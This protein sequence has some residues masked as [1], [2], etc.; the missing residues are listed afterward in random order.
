[1]SPVPRHEA[2]G[3]RELEEVMICS[4]PFQLPE[5]RRGLEAGSPCSDQH[6]KVSSS[7]IPHLNAQ[8]LGHFTFSWRDLFISYHH[9]KG[10]DKTIR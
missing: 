8:S 9:K 4:Q 3:V 7:L 10:E 6:P 1:M 2:V 5:V